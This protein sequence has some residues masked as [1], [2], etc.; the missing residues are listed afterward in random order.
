MYQC[1][2]GHEKEA[3]GPFEKEKGI[4][5]I[6]LYPLSYLWD[7]QLAQGWQKLNTKNIL[8]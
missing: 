2:T 3:G 4:A 5:W 8:V 7:V 6:P 1:Y